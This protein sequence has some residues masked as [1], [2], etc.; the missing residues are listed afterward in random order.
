MNPARQSRNQ[1]K[2]QPRIT[3]MARMRTGNDWISLPYIRVIRAIR[4]KNLH[5]K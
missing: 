4:G 3:L 5:Q 2:R 1:K